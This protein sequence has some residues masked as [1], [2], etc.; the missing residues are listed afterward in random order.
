[1]E[2]SH[3]DIPD[4]RSPSW[5]FNGHVHTI[6]CSLFGDTRQPPVERIEI[7]TPDDD[8][9][10][11][12]C[13]IQPDSEAVIVLFHGLEGSSQRYY[14][15]ELMK[16]LLDKSFSV[17]AVNF[18]SCGSKINKRARFYHSGETKDYATVFGWI[19]EHH[20]NKKL[21]AVGFSLGGNAL[22]KSLGEKGRNH[23]LDAAAAISVPYNLHLG[24]QVLSNGLNRVYELRFL[25]TLIKK[26]EVK[27]QRFPELPGFSGSTIFEFD[28]QVTGPV[29][30]FEG[31]LDYYNQCSS[32][33]FIGEIR[34]SCL[35]IHSRRD[36]FCPIEAMPIPAISKNPFTDYIITDEGGHVGF[37]SHPRGWLNYTTA[38]YLKSKLLDRQF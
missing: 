37:W 14:I 31:A 7:P 23:P 3:Q 6:F 12:D 5:C 34:T 32:G 9:L 19:R 2:T 33:Q 26:L 21:G 17:V 38:K 15:T 36:P 24:S 8:F 30:G 35:L 27:R 10:E 20:P 29:H 22:L 13:A 11:L 4:F 28:D 25:R 16:V 18:R 1:M